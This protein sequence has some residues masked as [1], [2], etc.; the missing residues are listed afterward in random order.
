[1]K[2]EETYVLVEYAFEY[3]SKDG[4]VITIKPNE[5]YILLRRT[6]DHWWHVRKSKNSRPFYIPVSSVFTVLQSVGS[7]LS[8]C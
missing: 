6:N 2:V 1:M 8:N 4:Q 3:T 5:R 7:L